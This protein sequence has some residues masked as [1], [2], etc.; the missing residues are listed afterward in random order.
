M[1]DFRFLERFKVKDVNQSSAL[2]HKLYSEDFLDIGIAED[3]LGFQLPKELKD[4][5]AQIGYGFFWQQNKASFDRFL[6]ADQVA[7][8]NLKEDFYEFDP[9]LELYDELYQGDKLLFFEV[10][11]GIYLARCSRC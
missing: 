9:D 8:I 4:F 3:K 7:Q 1:S 6:S 11:E 10:N 5:Y 2:N